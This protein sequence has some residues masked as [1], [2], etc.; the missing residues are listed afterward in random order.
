MFR[1]LVWRFRYAEKGGREY[2]T[3][4]IPRNMLLIGNLGEMNVSIL[5]LSPCP[6]KKSL[7][8]KLLYL[9]LFAISSRLLSTT[10]AKP[11]KKKSCELM[12]LQIPGL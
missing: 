1:K 3:V 10:R 7:H 4:N 8:P 12:Q 9:T 11:N 5:I 6:V 2:V